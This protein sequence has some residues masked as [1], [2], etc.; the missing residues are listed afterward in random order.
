MKLKRKIES[1][2]VHFLI[3]FFDH[4]IF[5]NNLFHDP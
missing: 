3:K 5:D 4:P 2:N 1:Q